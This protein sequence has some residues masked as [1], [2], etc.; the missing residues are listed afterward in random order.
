MINLKYHYKNDNNLII[1]HPQPM[2][3]IIAKSLE[4]S[5]PA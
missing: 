3:Y 4:L 1:L 2:F 5:K